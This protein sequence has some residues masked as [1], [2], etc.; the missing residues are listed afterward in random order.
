MNEKIKYQIFK[1]T[2]QFPEMGN[3][4]RITGEIPDGKGMPIKR[5]ESHKCQLTLFCSYLMM[6]VFMLSVFRAMVKM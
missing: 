2:Y 6:T 4:F 3:I 1:R 5:W